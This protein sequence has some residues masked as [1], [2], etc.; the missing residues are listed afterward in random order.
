VGIQNNLDLTHGSRSPRKP[1]VLPNHALDVGA[2]GWRPGLRGKHRVKLIVF[3]FDGTLVD[4]RALILACHRA[5]FTEFQL[6]LPSPQHSLALIGRS[7]ELVLAEL[8]GPAAPI[9]DMVQAYGR[10]LPQLRTDPAFAER[11]FEGIAALLDDLSRTPSAV[12]AIATGHT[13]TAD[14][15]AL[16]A[17]GWRDFFRT[18]QAADMAP[19]KP[20]PAMLM[21]ALAATGTTPDNA[22]FIG[23]TTFDMQMAKAAKLRSI[24]VAWGYHEAEQL[25]AAGAY[26]VASVVGELQNYIRDFL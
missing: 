7:L 17:L 24:G 25:V 23:D 16:D 12:L 3:D 19:S 26:R 13:S 8:A 4:S 15:P 18:I 22:I 1:R 2:T 10:L 5:V 9:P 6:P 20:N 21:Q 11:P 14:S